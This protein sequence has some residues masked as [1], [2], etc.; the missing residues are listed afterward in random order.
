MSIALQSCEIFLTDIFYRKLSGSGKTSIL[1]A[2]LGKE[3]ST[4]YGPSFTFNLYQVKCTS[5]HRLWILGLASQEVV[6]LL[7]CPGIMGTE[8]NYQR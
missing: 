2:L 8:R 4:F 5:S 6:A 3:I 7:R 1:M